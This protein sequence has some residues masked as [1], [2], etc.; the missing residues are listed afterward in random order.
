MT[1]KETEKWTK[2]QKEEADHLY[3]S[4]M[5]ITITRNN[6]KYENDMSE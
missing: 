6:K 2:L 4:Y 1:D 3:S 5:Q